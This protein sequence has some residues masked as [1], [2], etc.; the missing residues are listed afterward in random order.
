MLVSYISESIL[1]FGA[2]KQWNDQGLCPLLKS[3]RAALIRGIVNE[4]TLGRD[5]G[6]D[7][8]A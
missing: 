7:F 2:V 8:A 6:N 1:A 3:I 5:F 4:E